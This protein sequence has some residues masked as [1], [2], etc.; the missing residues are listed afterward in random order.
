MLLAIDQAKQLQQQLDDGAHARQDGEEDED[1]EP[2]TYVWGPPG[3]GDLLTAQL[4]TT[5]ESP[6]RERRELSSLKQSEASPGGAAS[7][8]SVSRSRALDTIAAGAHRRLSHHVVVTELVTT[9]GPDP[10]AAA[11]AATPMQPLGP[12]GASGAPA[13]PPRLWIRHLAPRRLADLASDLQ[14]CAWLCVAGGWLARRAASA[15]QGVRPAALSARSTVR[16]CPHGAARLLARAR[17]ILQ[18]AAQ[19][20]RLRLDRIPAVWRPHPAALRHAGARPTDLP[21][22]AHSPTTS[23]AGTA[24]SDDEAEATYGGRLYLALEGVVWDLQP[25]PPP[26]TAAARAQAGRRRVRCLAAQ[27][28]HRVPCWGYAFQVRPCAGICICL[29]TSAGPLP[30]HR[31]C[32][33]SRSAEA[34]ETTTHAPVQNAAAAAAGFACE[35]REA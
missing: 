34:R 23:S 25:P 27:L 11:G 8:S 2:V 7:S 16:A 15:P 13:A 17:V 18:A 21:S 6:E 28:Q 4:V 30:S 35:P 10:A 3:L 20:A 31:A 29:D 19:A 26:G 22:A 24:M 12:Q 5:G 32:Q 1:A 9:P 33:M 14:V